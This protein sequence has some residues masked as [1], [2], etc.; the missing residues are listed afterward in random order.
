MKSR[1]TLLAVC[2][3][4]L[5]IGLG[6][7]QARLDPQRALFAYTAGFV[8]A[9]A[10][11]VGALLFVSIAHTARA[12]WFVVFRR[13]SSALAAVLPIFLLL[14]LPIALGVRTLYPWARDLSTLD[15][16]ERAWAVHA[17]AWLNVPFFV[18]RSYV[19]L[20]LWSG[21]ALLLRRTSL[22]SD[23]EPS[24]ALVRR[25]RFLSAA[26]LPVFA[27]TLTG[28]AFDWVMSLDARWASDML[29][30]YLFAGTFAGSMGA[31]V[32][33]AWLA[34]RAKVLPDRVGPSH[35]HAL[36][37]VLLVA[38]I[39]W[40]YIAFCQFLLVWIADIGRESGF[41]VRRV[42]G[43]WTPFVVMLVL[44]HFVIPF[45]L[46]LSR[47]LKRRPHLLALVGAC[48]LC[49][50]ALDGYWLVVPALGR[51]THV[52]DLAFTVG[53]GALCAA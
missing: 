41:Y 44:Y 51:G 53:L 48:V 45:L 36:G 34:W 28:A 18:A 27:V 38:V 1:A 6:L 16:A 21:L 42:G 5:G 9:V 11:A 4:V 7:V 33:A 14:F 12:R 40:T 35:F 8:S 32:V 13:L 19:Y 47:S 17:H 30:L 23:A 29:G 39:F 52:L 31:L 22:A 25:E 2:L 20:F 24:Q 43:G 26:A 49:G 37:R 10:V 3:A 15:P 46:L 50:H